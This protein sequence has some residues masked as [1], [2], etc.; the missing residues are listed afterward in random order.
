DP[1]MPSRILVGTSPACTMIL[2]DATV[3]RRH[4]A[5]E[6]AGRRYRVSD[7]GSTN[8]TFVDG[9]CVLDGFVSGGEV[10]RCGS[11]AMCLERVDG[12]EPSPL[13]SAMRFGRMLG[14]SV[15]MRRL[16]PLC[17]RLAASAVPVLIE[18]ET[19]VGKENLAES[20]HEARQQPGPFV[21]LDCT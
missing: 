11:T 9:I 5:F 4:V 2:T 1:N 8:G 13:P 12:V 16:Y 14:A 21:V 17:E 3:S 10:V 20:L 6:P 19:G 7:L 15:A 18:G